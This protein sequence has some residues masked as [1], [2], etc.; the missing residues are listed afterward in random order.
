MELVKLGLLHYFMHKVPFPVYFILNLT[1]IINLLLIP[2]FVF[3][4]E[5]IPVLYLYV[6]KM[7]S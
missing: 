4:F 7:L 5:N 6:C 2:Y 3:Y 1:K